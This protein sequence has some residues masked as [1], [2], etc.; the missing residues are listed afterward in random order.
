MGDLGGLHGSQVLAFIEGLRPSSRVK[1]RSERKPGEPFSFL[2]R[3]AQSKTKFPVRKGR[4]KC[5]NYLKFGTCKFGIQCQYDHPPKLKTGNA[6]MLEECEKIELG[7]GQTGPSAVLTQTLFLTNIIA[8]YV[9]EAFDTLTSD[10][11]SG[12]ASENTF[13]VLEAVHELLDHM[14]PR[15]V[16][17]AHPHSSV[18]WRRY[19]YEVHYLVVNLAQLAD[20]VALLMK[21]VGIGMHAPGE[22]TLAAE[23]LE[24]PLA[25]LQSP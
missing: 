4:E 20:G 7:Q 23:L 14:L 1:G 16:N 17:S 19:G 18:A 12:A 9:D 2:A 24:G 3:A 21:R 22:E 8:D 10:L 5:M 6:L 13:W 15:L 25:E 11:K